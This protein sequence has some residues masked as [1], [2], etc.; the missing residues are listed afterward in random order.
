MHTLQ[1]WKSWSKPNQYFFWFLSTLLILAIGFFWYSYL[2]SPAPVIT[3]QHYQELQQEETPIRFVQMG[4]RSLPVQADI[5]M[6]TEAQLGSPLNPNL[7][8]PY[9]FLGSLLIFTLV[10]LTL[11]TTLSRFWFL[12]GVGIFSLLLI[13]L[14]FEALEVFGLVR[15]QDE[16]AR[17]LRAAH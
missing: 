2:L 3:W 10:S 7:T 4:L 16:D 12:I 8:A 14:Q 9:I 6:I 5:F 11:I 17:C 15:G 13:S 1:F